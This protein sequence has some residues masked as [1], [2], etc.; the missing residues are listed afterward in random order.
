MTVASDSHSNMYGGIGCLGTPIVRTDA[1]AIW[2]TGR[3]W[4]QVPQVVKVEFK[5]KLNPGVTG[6]DV[7]IALCGILNKDEVLNTAIEFTGE[8]VASLTVDERLTI[9]NMTTEWGALAGVFPVDETTLSWI[10]K[11]SELLH[12]WYENNNQIN[13]HENSY[14]SESNVK[15]GWKDRAQLKRIQGIQNNPIKPD[16]NSH[17]SACIEIDLST[18]PPYVSGP[19][20]VKIATPLPQLTS[21]HIPIQKA[22]LVSCVNSRASDLRQA[23]NVIKESQKKI[24]SSVEFYVAAASSKIQEE[25]EKEGV[26]NTLI[27]AGAKT[28]PAGCGPCIGKGFFFRF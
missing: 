27:Q 19:N 6:K 8:G 22:Y 11:Q 7:I 26:W 16:A 25:M 17:Y 14:S 9:S 3:T 1:A 4:W 15:G 18:I 28:L 24:A 10:K 21:Q 20:S 2:A 13:N 5:G 12:K 23:A